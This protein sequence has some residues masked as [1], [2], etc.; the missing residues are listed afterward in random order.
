MTK[1][2][3]TQTKHTLHASDSSLLMPKIFTKF[4]RDHLQQ[5]AK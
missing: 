2:R 3:I 1:P 5:G 4:R